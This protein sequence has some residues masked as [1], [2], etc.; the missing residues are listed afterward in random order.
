VAAPD[1]CTSYSL[2]LAAEDVLP[3]IFGGIGY[4]YLAKRVELTVPE[5]AWPARI[6]GLLLVLGSIA[7]GPVRKFLVVT[8]DGIGCL[9][10]LQNPFFS[11]LP[12]CFAILAWA[13]AS[14]WR[15]QKARIWPFAGFAALAVIAALARDNRALLL[16]FGGLLAVATA[17]FGALVARKQGDG[18]TVALFTVNGLGTLA[19]PAIGTNKAVSDVTNQWLAQ[20][21]NTVS[22]AAFGLACYRLF[23]VYAA[24]RD[25]D[26][27]GVVT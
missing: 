15:G 6:A 27:S 17:V 14:V 22:Q 2:A 16:A 12:A 1:V 23:S 4:W 25:R 18:W 26:P 10:L 21:I 13:L 24:N 3:I 20:G 11:L 8:D 19:L 9:P 7:A 5:A